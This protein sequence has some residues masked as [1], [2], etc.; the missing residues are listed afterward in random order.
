V[1]LEEGAWTK[2]FHPGW[3]AVAGITAA[4]LAEQGF[5]G[6]SRPYEGKFGLFDTHLQKEAGHVDLAA[7]TAGLG[8]QWHFGDTALKPYPVCHFIHG[9]ADAAI[10]LHREIA[11][12]DAPVSTPICRSRRCTSIAEPAAAKERAT[13]EYEA[14]F[15]TQ[16]VVSRELYTWRQCITTQMF[17]IL[18][19]SVTYC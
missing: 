17:G 8:A 12:V 16:Y 1:F 2:R 9:C 15:S 13:T 19:R 4:R 11:A 10:E 7:L 3:A 6:P 5:I 14:K 18:L